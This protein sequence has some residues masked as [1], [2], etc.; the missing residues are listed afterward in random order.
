MSRSHH[1]SK[2]PGERLR[3]SR[4]RR[5]WRLLAGL[6]V[7]ALLTLYWKLP[8]VV[9]RSVSW[10]WSRLSDEPLAFEVREA[11]WGLVAL[12]NLQLSGAAGPIGAIGSIEAGFDAGSLLQGKLSALEL[13]GIQTVVQQ[14]EGQWH[15][16]LL[17]L[18]NKRPP[19]KGGADFPER[20]PL[21]HLRISDSRLLFEKQNGPRFGGIAID[22]MLEELAPEIW[23]LALNGRWQPDAESAPGLS[24]GLP[25]D[26]SVS[27]Q[28]GLTNRTLTLR[29]EAATARNVAHLWCE[30]T[31]PQAGNWELE[32][33]LP[34]HELGMD[35]D[36][37]KMLL[38]FAP[39]EGLTVSGSVG[40]HATL[41]SSANRL[42][43]SLSGGVTNLA[44]STANW[45]VRGIDGQ[46]ELMQRRERLRTF[47]EQVLRFESARVAAMG[48]DGGEIRW[49]MEPGRIRVA[50][51]DLNWLGGQLHAYALNFDL[52][53]HDTEFVLYV[54]GIEVGQLLQLV[55]PLS[56]SGEG[57]LYGRIPVRYA[58]GRWR[59][60]TAYLYSIPGQEGL[61]QLHDTR[62]LEALLQQAGLSREV[63]QN[64]AAAL[65]DF[66]FTAFAV[67][68]HPPETGAEL[69]L[70]IRLQGKSR[71]RHRPTPVDAT[72]NLRGPLE[73]L[74]NVGVSLGQWQH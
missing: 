1:K 53:K 14:R 54:D 33:H 16:P 21:R 26:L 13:S 2:R 3:R 62:P 52:N 20:I 46:V 48:F 51:A 39:I 70:T 59:L 38:K 35:D 24:S 5:V 18:L 40:G 23:T 50:S 49:Q 36:F 8:Q 34:G 9:G 19:G 27:V 17:D 57:R 41:R 30:V 11:R 56:G 66:Q 58:D 22:G 25:D 63:R 64:L 72:L 45:E 32:A 29:A 55:K 43:T 67:E 61:I 73:T 31:L 69:L 7:V 12:D 44:A 47:G 4:R 74:L 42:S 15:L 37:T 65:R 10:F 71:D 28:G 6:L 60:S 68:L